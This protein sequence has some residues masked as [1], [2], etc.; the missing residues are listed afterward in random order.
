M[1][2]KKLHALTSI[3]IKSNYPFVF[4]CMTQIQVPHNIIIVSNNKLV[5][6]LI[7]RENS[8]LSS[9]HFREKFILNPC[10]QFQVIA[11]FMKT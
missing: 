3:V 7:T 2:K 6:D 1:K 11:E 5:K 9:T 10:A 8:E 4:L